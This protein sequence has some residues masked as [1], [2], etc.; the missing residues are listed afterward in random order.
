MNRIAKVS[1]MLGTLLLGNH[2]GYAA[3]NA[4]HEF[5]GIDRVTAMRAALV[6][7][8]DIGFVIESADIA[9][10]TIKSTR[11]AE[12]PEPQLTMDIAVVGNDE[13]A[14]L[15]AALLVDGKAVPFHHIAYHNFFLDVE[16]KVSEM[17]RR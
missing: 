17:S 4:A 7:L 8:Q 2:S 6:A 13:G 1:L 10:W 3:E 16:Q 9:K 14:V 15:Q 11:F 5:N 12:N